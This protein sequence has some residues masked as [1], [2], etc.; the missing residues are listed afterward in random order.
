MEFD[1]WW[2]RSIGRSIGEDRPGVTLSYAQSLDGSIAKYRGQSL[3]LSGAESRSLT[4]RLRAAHDAILVGIGTILSDD[5]Q[6]NVRFAEGSDPQVIVLDSQLR[7]P[8]DA[9]IFGTGRPII[10]CAASATMEAQR[11]LEDAG[12]HVEH[13]E[14][15]GRVELPP[16]LDVLKKQGIGSLMVEGGGEVIS[17]FVAERL[18]DRV[19][20]TIAP[21]FVGGYKPLPDLANGLTL[22]NEG[23]AQFGK[24]IVFWGDV[25]Q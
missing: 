9:K 23:S 7:T 13:Q 8:T 20:I 5:P 12:A 3:A 22:V 21:Q 6:L 1:D 18:I 25:K 16:M 4:H 19:V 2:V 17:N 14:I 10:F 24:D 11:K 15:D